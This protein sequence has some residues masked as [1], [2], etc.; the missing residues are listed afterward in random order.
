MGRGTSCICVRKENYILRQ[1]SSC[2]SGF[3]INEAALYLTIHIYIYI[4]IYMVQV[5]K[6]R[7]MRWAGHVALMGEERWVCTVLLVKPE[8]KRPLGRTRRRS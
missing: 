6:F 1:N 2:Y 3:D 5:K 4:Y 7:R 8:E